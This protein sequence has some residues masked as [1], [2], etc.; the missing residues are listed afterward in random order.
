MY[1]CVC[2]SDEERIER[3]ESTT[4]K[5]MVMPTEVLENMKEKVEAVNPA[6]REGPVARAIEAETARLPSDV[7]LWASIGAMA[8]SLTLKLMGKDHAA[9]FIGQWTAPFLLFG[10][11]NK[12]VK[13]EGHDKDT[14]P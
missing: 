7:F 14:R 10:V 4:K 9:T 11:Y 8:A 6:R 1:G 12:I 2:E 13:T 5:E 3:K